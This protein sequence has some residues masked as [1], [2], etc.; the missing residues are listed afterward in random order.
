MSTLNEKDLSFTF[1]E[2]WQAEHFD[3]PGR[4]TLK[5]FQ[6]VD[7]VVETAERM[8]FIEVKDP[9]ATQAPDIQ[10][11]RFLQQ[12][13]SKELTH[14]QLVPKART[15]WAVLSLL[16]RIQKPIT[17]IVVIGAE[18][19]QVDPALWL[20]LTDKL[21]QRLNKE[22]DIPWPR[23]YIQACIVLPAS[24]LPQHLP[25]VSVRRLTGGL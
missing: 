3:Q 24:D 25:G 6:P 16:Q 11:Q 15:S 5:H 17:Y 13:Q 14:E 23:P 18:Q 20:H 8:F 22:I 4:P 12:M 10:R 21:K 19:L 9:S 7:F 1:P 2:E